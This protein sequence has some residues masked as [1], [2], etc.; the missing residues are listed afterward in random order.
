MHYNA[1]QKSKIILKFG[2]N[3]IK[4]TGITE[5]Q[6]ALLTQRINA[7]KSH[8]NKHKQDHHS[9]R[10]LLHIVTRRRKLLK[11]LK[12]SSVLRYNNLIESLALRH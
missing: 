12:K 7:L 1:E 2:F 3:N 8:F 9:R 5:V 6:V 10:G 11:Y 4:N